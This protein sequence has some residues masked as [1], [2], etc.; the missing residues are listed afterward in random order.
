MKLYAKRL[1]LPNGFAEDQVVTVEGGR[2]TAIEA[3]TIGDLT[4]PILAPGYFDLHN[5]GGEGY[6]TT[7]LSMELLT[8]FLTRLCKSGVTDILI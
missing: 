5:H 6:D 3:G 2:I 1:L 7:L 8:K 4:A